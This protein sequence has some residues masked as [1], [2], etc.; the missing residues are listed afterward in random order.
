MNAHLHRDDA[1][2]FA[3]TRRHKGRVSETLAGRVYP[4]TTASGKRS[5]GR[6]SKGDRHAFHV[7][8]PRATADRVIAWADATGVSYSDVI[9]N[10]V[11]EHRDEIDPQLIEHGSNRLDLDTAE[12]A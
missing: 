9:S 3:A 1:S 11:E 12:S 6:P 4:M 2:M 8:I 5:T 7:R 10:L